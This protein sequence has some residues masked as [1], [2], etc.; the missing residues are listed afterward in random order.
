VSHASLRIPGFEVLEPLAEGGFGLVLG[1]RRLADGR[2]A[3]IKLARAGLPAAREQLSR[4]AAALRAAGPELVP[5]LLAE[6]TSEHG[7]PFLA[8]ERIRGASLSA[9]LEAGAGPL[10]AR[11]LRGAARAL[12][13]ALAALH[14]R[15]VAHGD[16]KPAHVLLEGGRARLLDLGLS[17]SP[18]LPAPALAEGTFVGTA[19]YMSPEACGGAGASAES[20]VYAAGCILFQLATG[21]PPFTGAPSEVRLAHVSARPPRPS[22][23]APVSDALEAVLLRCLAKAPAERFP[24]GAALRA[25]LL[26][27]LEAPPPPR[28]SSGVAA[29]IAPERRAVAVLRFRSDADLLAIRGAVE[30]AGGRLALTLPGRHAAV[31][32]PAAEEN[33][34]RRALAAAAALARAGVTPRAVVDLETLLV[35]EAGAVRRYVGALDRAAAFPAAADP[36][37]ALLTAAAAAAVPEL[38]VAPVRDGLL[39]PA[40]APPAAPA[41][42]LVGRAPVLDALAGEL[43][44]ALAGEGPAVIALAGAAGTGKTR[45]SAE[46]A[47]RLGAGRA[48]PALLSLRAR[49]GAGETLRALLAALLPGA[50]GPAP[51]DGGHALLAPELPA[52]AGPDAWAAAALALGWIG[53]TH[54]ALARAAAA[55]GALRAATLR[56]VGELLRARARARPLL[57]VL[58]DAHLADPAALDALEYAAL[59][60]AAAPVAVLAAGR[61]SLLAARPALGERAARARTFELGALERSDAAELARRLLAPA[62]AVPAAAIDALVARTG[63]VPLLL[64]ELVRALRAEGLVFRRD[65]D[66]PALVATELVSSVPD[67]PLAAWLADRELGALSDGLAAH[68]RIAALLGGEAARAELAGTVAELDREAPGTATLDPGWATDRLVERGLLAPAGARVAFRSPLLR[69]ALVQGAPP[70]LR[71]AV[72]RAAFRH[73]AARLPPGPERLARLEVHAA[74][75]GRR[76]EAA[77]LAL[78]LAEELRSRHADLEAEAAYGR[79]AAGLPEGE[80]RAL[81]EALRGRGRVRIRLGRYA[82]AVEDLGRSRVL[83]RDAGDAAAEVEA[84]LDEATALDWGNAWAAATARVEEAE[85][86]AGARPGPLVSARLALARGRTFVRAGRFAHA[87]RALAAASAAGAALGDAGYETRLV[88]L[89]LAGH[90]LPVLGRA[91]EAEAALAEAIALATARGDLLHLGAA[92]NNRRNLSVAR[93]DLARARDDLARALRIGRDLGMIGSEYVY[94]FNLGEL[95]HQAGEAARAAPHVA[96]AVEIER[97]HPEAA[98]AP[99]ARLLAARRA[100]HAGELAAARALLEEVE[101]AA[102]APRGALGP[103]D[104][105]LADMVRLALAAAPEEAWRTLRARSRTDSVEQEP[106]EVCEQHGLT[107]LRA[108][109][110]EEGIAALEDALRLAGEIPS[111]GARRLEAALARARAG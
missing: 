47:E 99:L 103:S 8:E 94:R 33:P 12:A 92:L 74:G 32:E 98:P 39:A 30:A 24:D 77:A 11:E 108:G 62:E 26:P 66:G 96:R 43:G 104:R 65:P 22:A 80:P 69:E 82:E 23:L 84:L 18:G 70:A 13:D 85:G 76:A 60:E 49:E 63:G 20:D 105:V 14:G 50:A 81:A 15:G 27:A 31:L 29:G 72:H 75:S 35:V 42:P 61:P 1:A 64:V 83:F 6:G 25:A 19:A 97:R 17:R 52:A 44:A 100:A 5:E 56:A 102:A 37:G 48:G 36:E 7:E 58:D 101:A 95:E 10:E 45:L 93:G 53:P 91:A 89:L 79:A 3:A 57:V 111:L 40:A 9:L 110:R 55:P 21:R 109:R 107:A 28:A 67:L 41:A 68:A 34:V 73:L 2:E 78:A 88:A 4:E 90:V 51:A 106:I 71:E 38:P 87:A 59:A 54:P 16:L 46:V 86:R